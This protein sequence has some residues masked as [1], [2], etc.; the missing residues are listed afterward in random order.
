MTRVFKGGLAVG[1]RVRVVAGPAFVAGRRNAIKGVVEAI[2]PTVP[3]E[4]IMVRVTS[5]GLWGF[6]SCDLKRVSA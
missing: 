4:T 1:H 5:G 2:E 6:R 3:F